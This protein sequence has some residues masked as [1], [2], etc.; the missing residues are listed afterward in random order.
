MSAFNLFA[1]CGRLPFLGFSIAL[2]NALDGNVATQNV[3]TRSVRCSLRCSLLKGSQLVPTSIVQR[4]P[5]FRIHHIPSS[6][7][8][9]PHLRNGESFSGPDSL[10][11]SYS[12]K[13]KAL[14][15]F[16][17]Y[18]M[19]R[20]FNEL[21]AT[22]SEGSTSALHSHSPPPSYGSGGYNAQ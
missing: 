2:Y 4:S 9:L 1:I 3:C 15:A 12:S 5:V 11:F 7:G 8:L 13:E 19:Y 16:I 22:I 21:P 17:G 18:I 6:S 14:Q 20:H 10:K